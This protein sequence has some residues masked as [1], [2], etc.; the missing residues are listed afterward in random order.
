MNLNRTPVSTLG[1]CKDCRAYDPTER[2]RGYCKRTDIT[3]DAGNNC[4][5]FRRRV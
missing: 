4:R 5:H 1:Y 2:D 3:V